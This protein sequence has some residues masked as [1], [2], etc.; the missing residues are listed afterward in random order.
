MCAS[1]TG[2]DFLWAAKVAGCHSA[3]LHF[4]PGN[5]HLPLQKCIIPHGAGIG[6]PTTNLRMIV[7]HKG[8]HHTFMCQHLKADNPD[9]R[10]L[11]YLAGAYGSRF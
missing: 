11:H 8:L 9:L 4:W 3:G 5:L 1:H 6:Q 2:Q 7:S 10:V